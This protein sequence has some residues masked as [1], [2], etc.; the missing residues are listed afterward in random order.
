M[1]QDIELS[2]FLSL[3]FFREAVSDFANKTDEQIVILTRLV[4]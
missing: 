1:N 2:E 4:C 3:R